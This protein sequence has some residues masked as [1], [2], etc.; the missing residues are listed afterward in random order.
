V[1]GKISPSLW[2]EESIPNTRLLSGRR[3]GLHRPAPFDQPE[4]GGYS[5]LA[6]LPVD[7]RARIVKCWRWLVQAKTGT[8]ENCWVSAMLQHMSQA[9]VRVVYPGSAVDDGTMD[10]R[11]LASALLGIG[12][13]CQAASRVLNGDDVSVSVRVKADFKSGS[14]DVYL[15]LVQSLLDHVKDTLYGSEQV[16]ATDVL[17]LLGFLGISVPGG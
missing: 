12:D 1:E 3:V 13:L 14:F 10:V 9:T 15:Q 8:G 7:R 4:K 2:T 5:R 16:S 17:T 11:D 6:G